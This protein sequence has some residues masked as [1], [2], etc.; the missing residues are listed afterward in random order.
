MSVQFYNQ[1]SSE[2]KL[3]NH[4]VPKTKGPS[5]MKGDS[6]HAEPLANSYLPYFRIHPQVGIQNTLIS[7]NGNLDYLINPNGFCTDIHLELVVANIG[8]ANI[9]VTPWASIRRIEWIG[10]DGSVISTIYGWQLYLQNFE[11]SYDTAKRLLGNEGLSLTTYD[12]DAPLAPGD[13]RTYLLQIPGW[14]KVAQPKFNAFNHK[15]NIKIQFDNICVDPAV[16]GSLSLLSADLITNGYIYYNES[17]LTD[18]R[19]SQSLHYRYLEYLQMSVQ[20]PMAPNGKYDIR[21]TNLN[22]QLVSC[23]FVFIRSL[24]VTNTNLTTFIPIERFSM[25]DESGN[26][27][28]LELNTLLLKNIASKDFIGDIVNVKQNLYPISF[29]LDHS[30]DMRGDFT[31][32]YAMGG[33]ENITI[34]TKGDLVPGQYEITVYAGCYQMINIVK[35]VISSTK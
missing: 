32:L 7:A 19:K 5:E 15:I 33:N 22:N 21:L 30:R 23:L 12:A 34:T 27:I 31:G 3:K 13:S 24:P 1:P 4:G 25:K 26:L 35:G 6:K 14:H 16:V 8:L 29:S 2:L 11:R 9:T 20:F 10:S 18:Y 28:G 17:Q